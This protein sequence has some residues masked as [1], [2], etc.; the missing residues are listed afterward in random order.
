MPISTLVVARRRSAAARHGAVRYRQGRRSSREF[1]AADRARSPPTSTSAQAAAR[2]AWSATPTSVVP[3]PTTSRSACAAPRP[4]YEAI[5]AK[6]SPEARGK[7]R[8][9]SSNDPTAPVDNTCTKGRWHHEDEDELLDYTLICLLAGIAPLAAAQESQPCRRHRQAEAHRRSR[10]ESRLHRHRAVRSEGLLIRVRTRGERKPVTA[11]R[12]RMPPRKTLQPDRR[13]T[14]EAE[15]PG[16]AVAIGKWSVQLPNGGVIWATED[17]NLGQAELNVSAPSFVA[18]DGQRITQAGA[19]LRLQQLF[20]LHQA[21]TRCTIYRATDAD[22][23]VA[24]RHRAAAGRRRQRSR[25][26]RHVAARHRAAR[27]RRTAL[28]R[29]RLRRGRQL[30]R[31]LSAPAAT[32]HARKKPNAA[33]S[34]CATTSRTSSAPPSAPS[35]PSSRA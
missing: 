10:R 5:A 27:R 7:V 16:K 17:P 22:L 24:D 18:F 9:E 28:H 31:N 25:V 19:V 1:R 23:V 15:Q 32:G 26:G 6:L 8:V 13:V 20:G 3:M 21:R 34:C 35:K 2:S 4:C 14:V 33:R 12:P 11:A 29:A 30:R